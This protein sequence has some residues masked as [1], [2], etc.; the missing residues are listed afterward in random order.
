MD[1]FL[2]LYKEFFN[3]KE[4]KNQFHLTPLELKVY[5]NIELQRSFLLDTTIIHIDTLLF[6]LD[7]KATTRNKKQVEEVL[8]ELSDKEIISILEEHSGTYKIENTFSD[9]KEHQFEKIAIEELH[10]VLREIE[11]D[12]L[13]YLYLTLKAWENQEG[14]TSFSNDALSNICQAGKRTVQRNLKQLQDEKLISIQRGKYQ[15]NIIRTLGFTFCKI[16]EELEPIMLKPTCNKDSL[17]D[18]KRAF[19]I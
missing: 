6:L 2:R 16:E 15:K 14:N 10:Y 1:K 9:S 19:G 8:K 7:K 4:G 3:S 13:L 5:L 17:E 12:S 18:I 11:S